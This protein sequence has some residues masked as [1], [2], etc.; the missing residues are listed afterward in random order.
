MIR[1]KLKLQVAIK[2]RILINY[3]SNKVGSKVN[4][5][6]TRERQKRKKRDVE[7]ECEDREMSNCGQG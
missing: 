2:A 7:V 6:E 1:I 5:G 3:I 4:V